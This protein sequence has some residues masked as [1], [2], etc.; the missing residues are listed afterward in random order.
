VTNSDTNRRFKRPLSPYD[1]FDLDKFVLHIGDMPAPP[2]LTPNTADAVCAWIAGIGPIETSEVREIHALI[3]RLLQTNSAAINGARQWV[4]I[5]GPPLT[6]KTFATFVA[7]LRIGAQLRRTQA[8]DAAEP[9]DHIPVVIVSGHLGDTALARNLL[10]NIARFIG[11]PLP[12]GLPAATETLAHRLRDVGA[13]LV[14]VDDAHF[15]KR[16][17]GSRTLTDNL[18]DIIT[19]LPVS[20]VFVGAGLR[21]SALLHVP[22]DVADT[23]TRRT[24]PDQQR[25]EDEQFS[26]VHQLRE[27]MLFRTVRIH[28]T[29]NGTP[30]SVLRGRLSRLVDQLERIEGYDPSVLRDD[31]VTAAIAARAQGKT[32]LAFKI[33]IQIAALA[34]AAG[35]SPTL[36]Y[37]TAITGA[38]FTNA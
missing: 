19:T 25:F 5:D 23:R 10:D 3:L 16:K 21:S 31:P 1:R 24:T 37:V 14:V 27:R 2:P 22:N 7:A 32:G 34:A 15:I 18:K 4:G 36:A 8:D 35:E 11:V 29:K 9:F 12:T 33:A 20:F 17:N 6:G 28:P 38:E 13:L 26:A 30:H